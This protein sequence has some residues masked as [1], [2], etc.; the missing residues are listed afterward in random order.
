MNRI[1]LLLEEVMRLY[2]GALLANDRLH[3][4]GAGQ[5]RARTTASRGT[6]KQQRAQTHRRWHLAAF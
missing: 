5:S 2:V 1:S 6:C 4:S 3:D